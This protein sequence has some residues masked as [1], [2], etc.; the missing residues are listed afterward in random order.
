MVDAGAMLDLTD[1]IDKYAPNIK[2]LYGD[3]MKRLR[4]SNS[5]KA[6]Y[7]IPSYAVDQK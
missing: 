5:D 3:Q 6:I 1:L 7:V 2:K 4:Y